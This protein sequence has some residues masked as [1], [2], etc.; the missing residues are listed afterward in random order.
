MVNLTLWKYPSPDGAE[1][2]LDRLRGL[3]AQRL[4]VVEHA[5]V[6]TWPFGKSSP[7]TR[8]ELSLSGAWALDS[9]FWGLLFGLL[10]HTTLLHITED[11]MDRQAIARQMD[12]IGIGSGFIQAA[13]QLVTQDTSALFLLA[14]DEVV[15]RVRAAFQGTEFG[16]IATR[17]AP[18]QEAMLRVAFCKQAG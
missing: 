14:S 18:E 4:I 6:V 17:L 1:W 9:A 12:A 2:A 11:D 5:A 7:F 13:Q 3:Q 15:K 16:F 10:F 8:H